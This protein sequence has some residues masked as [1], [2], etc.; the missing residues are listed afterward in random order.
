MKI[1]WMDGYVIGVSEA[2]HGSVHGPLGLG[3]LTHPVG[4]RWL[5]GGWASQHDSHPRQDL[6]QGLQ[7]GPVYREFKLVPKKEG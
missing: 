3:R 2:A 7:R 6:G 5:N 4:E 1:V